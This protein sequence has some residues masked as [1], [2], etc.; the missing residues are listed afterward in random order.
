MENIPIAG[1]ACSYTHSVGL[2]GV[3]A[4]HAREKGSF[5]EV[6]NLDPFVKSQNARSYAL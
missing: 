3:G 6:V 2:Y 4:S 5:Y 1:M